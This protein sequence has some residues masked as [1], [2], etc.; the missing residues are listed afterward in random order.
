MTRDS[1]RDRSCSPTTSLEPR[2]LATS[3][4]PC[5]AA[6]NAPKVAEHRPN[7]TP[8]WALQCHT[9]QACAR[10]ATRHRHQTR[11]LLALSR[12]SPY[13]AQSPRSRHREGPAVASL[14]DPPTPAQA[15]AGLRIGQSVFRI[16][17][18]GGKCQAASLLEAL[19]AS[20]HGDPLALQADGVS[21]F[22][23]PF[24]SLPF[25]VGSDACE[26]DE[27]HRHRR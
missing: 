2:S 21:R 10:A 3:D 22:L 18:D 25:L 9:P 16:S 23:L 7:L 14:N 19:E 1:P 4:V 26:S 8:R 13:P 24:P 27:I 20:N 12:C 5:T 15:A 11:T 6:T 17:E